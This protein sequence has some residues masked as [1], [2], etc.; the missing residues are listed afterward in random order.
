MHKL[1]AH[2]FA[3]IVSLSCFAF[4]QHKGKI[5]KTS[6]ISILFIGNSLTYYNDLPK[7]ITEEAKSKDIKVN[8]TTIA[9]PNYALVD[10]WKDGKVQ[11][12]IK[13]DMFDYVIVQQGPSSQKEGRQ[14]LIEYGEKYNKLC[15]NYNTQLCFFMVWPSMQ[16]YRTFGG[17]IANYREAA[18]VNDAILLPVGKVWK[19][20]FDKTNNFDFYESDGFHPSLKGSK[21]AADVILNT[22]LKHKLD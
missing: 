16:Y 12:L 21:K 10:H 18:K 17:V 4:Q 20:H 14:M 22:L 19:A 8:T 6:E 5:S 9:Y 15:K 7:L 1:F 13:S 3:F 11:K 2:I